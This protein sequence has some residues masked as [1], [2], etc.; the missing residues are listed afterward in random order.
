M[1]DS[2][3]EKS[4][5]VHPMPGEAFRI[6]GD[7]NAQSRKLKATF[8]QLIDEDLTFVVVKENSLMKRIEKKLNK[9][10]DEV[11]EIIKNAQP[12]HA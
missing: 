1:G 12:I 10:R 6:S 3:N 4:T 8:T 5:E 7:W 9:T 11:I 2:K